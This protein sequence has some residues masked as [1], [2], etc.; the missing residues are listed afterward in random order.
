VPQ[1]QVL[2]LAHS[3]T[4]AQVQGLHLQWSVMSFS[5][6]V[7]DIPLAAAGGR[8]LN[9]AAIVMRTGRGPASLRQ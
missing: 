5:L 4:G 1:L 3:Q 8:E 2:P 7:D 6:V 9:A